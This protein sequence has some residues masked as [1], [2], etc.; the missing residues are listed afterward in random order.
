MAR[1]KNASLAQSFCDYLN[2]EGTDAHIDPDGDVVFRDGR[3][4]YFAS[5]DEDGPYYFRLVF[6]NF[7]EVNSDNRD[8]VLRVASEITGDI[9][10]VKV[11]TVRDNVWASVEQYVTDLEQ[12]KKIF[13]RSKSC[14]EHAVL[15]FG[16]KMMIEGLG[17]S[18]FGGLSL[19]L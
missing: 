16:M 4:I 5:F 9:K 10:A 14:L 3:G 2:S 6:P 7:F 19:D 12:A 13:E 1:E 8:R 17:E 15:L 11:F 18:P